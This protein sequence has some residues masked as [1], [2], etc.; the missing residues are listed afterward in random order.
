M[1]AQPYYPEHPPKIVFILEQPG[2]EDLKHGYPMAGSTGK[3]FNS[4]MATAGLNR[5][6]YAFVYLF[7]EKLPED[8]WVSAPVAKLGGFHSTEFSSVLGCLRP[9][10]RHHFVRLGAELAALDA[11]MAVAI[12]SIPFWALSGEGSAEKY[13]GNAMLA[14]RIREG[15]KFLPT[16]HPGEVR[17]FWKLYSVVVGDLMRAAREGDRGPHLFYPERRL[18][19]NPTEDEVYQWCDKYLPGSELISVDI[20]TG[21]GQITSIGFASDEENAI[22]I[23]FV[24]PT[25]PSKSYWPTAEKE[26]R[27]WMRV[28]SILE[29]DQP[30]L[31]QNF[32][33]YDV[34]WLWEKMGI[35][36]RNLSEDTRLMHHA[37]YPELPKDLAFLGAAYTDQGPWKAMVSHRAAKS[38]TDKA[39]N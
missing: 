34:L 12:G 11:P 31:G 13:R 16:V 27:I 8:A 26:C 14:S 37:L 1:V 20:E 33:Q 35:A 10:Y 39:D 7:N 18:L 24:N 4:L 6:D 17:K 23:P 38:K 30:K 21:W 29:N 5:D 32:G 28:K 3:L 36:S 15:Q 22:C 9:E 25:A 19:V 2:T